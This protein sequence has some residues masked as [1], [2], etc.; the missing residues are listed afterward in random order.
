MTATQKTNQIPLSQEEADR[1]Q[2]YFSAWETGLQHHP[3]VPFSAYDP[4]MWAN[5]RLWLNGRRVIGVPQVDDSIQ[6]SLHLLSDRLSDDGMVMDFSAGHDS[7]ITF[8][9]RNLP[10]AGFYPNQVRIL[11]G[12][13]VLGDHNI[14][15]EAAATVLTEVLLGRASEPGQFANYFCNGNQWLAGVQ[16]ADHGDNL[17]FRLQDGREF[18]VSRSGEFFIGSDGTRLASL[19]HEA[20]GAEN[21]YRGQPS[22][23]LD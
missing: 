14:A 12:G 13:L 2:R 3:A 20:I 23:P 11:R 4:G 1:F 5:V 18:K 6:G 22:W 21:P 15:G 8:T 9:F 7:R 17:L 16:V 19:P 10:R